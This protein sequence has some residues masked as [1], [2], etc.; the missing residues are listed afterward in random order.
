MEPVLDDAWEEAQLASAGSGVQLQFGGIETQL[1]QAL[2]AVV[3]AERLVDVELVGSGQLAPQL[4]VGRTDRLRCGDG[5]DPVGQQAAG[6]QV[7]QSPAT[8]W[9]A[10]ARS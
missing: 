1:V 6:L 9:V 8:F 4:L 3:D 10:I 2:Q 7:L 5:I